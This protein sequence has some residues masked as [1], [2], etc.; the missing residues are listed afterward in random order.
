MPFS[1]RATCGCG[2]LEGYLDPRNGQDCVFCAR[3]HRFQYNA[4]KIETGKKERSVQTTHELVTPSKRA[5]VLERASARC[6][7]CGTS[8]NLHVSHII[9]VSDGYAVGLSDEDINSSENL[10]CLCEEC[11]LGM[12][13]RSFS[14]RIYAIL[15]HRRLA[16][17]EMK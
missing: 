16:V 8:S 10:A 9:S 17:L 6:E 7:L 14:P 4:P 15:L 11:N 3:C 13:R 1:L 12:G 5:G 2:S